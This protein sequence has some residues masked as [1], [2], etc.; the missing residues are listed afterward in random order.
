M[1][2]MSRMWMAVTRATGGGPGVSDYAFD[3]TIDHSKVDEDLFDF[4]LLVNLGA[5][6][7]IDDF[8]AT[9]IFD[10]DTY[11]LNN[12]SVM[13]NKG[14]GKTVV[15]YEGVL[16]SLSP[17]NYWDFNDTIASGTA[18]DQISGENGV[19]YGNPTFESESLLSDKSLSSVDFDG[20]D[21]IESSVNPTLGDNFSFSLIFKADTIPNE[22]G[23][24]CIRQPGG[25]G[26]VLVSLH[27]EA[28]YRMY[29]GM[30]I[31]STW[32]KTNWIGVSVGA[33]YHIAC[34]KDGTTL[35]LYIDGAYVRGIT[36]PEFTGTVAQNPFCIGQKYG[37]EGFSGF[38]GLIDQVATWKTIALSQEQVEELY[39]AF[40]YVEEN[41]IYYN[42]VL[43]LSPK[44]Y[45]TLGD[46]TGETIIIDEL[47][48]NNGTTVNSPSLG[49]PS[50]LVDSTYTAIDFDGST[51]GQYVYLGNSVFDNVRT[52]SFIFKPDI[53][54]QA[55]SGNTG[56]I[57]RWDN[58]ATVSNEN[59]FGF[60]IL[61]TTGEMRF[62]RNIGTTQHQIVSG[63]TVWTSGEIYHIIGIIDSA[64]GMSLYINGVKQLSV[65]SSTEVAQPFDS[66]CVIGSWGSF[67]GSM[68]TFNGVIDEVSVFN[69]ALTETEV[70]YLYNAS[71]TGIVDVAVPSQQCKV[72]IDR[73]DQINEQAQLWVKVPYVSKDVDT[74]INL[75]FDPTNKDNSIN[76]G[77]TGEAP[78]QAVW[79]E[80]DAVYHLSKTD[81]DDYTESTV[82]IYLAQI[83]GTSSTTSIAT[84]GLSAINTGADFVDD[85]LTIDYYIEDISTVI[86]SQIE[87]SSAGT[88]DTDDVFWELDSEFSAV[89]GWN[90]LTLYLRNA[91]NTAG[92][93][94]L[95]AINYIR[96]YAAS[97]IN[98]IVSFQNAIMHV[99][100]ITSNN[101][102]YDSTANSLDGTTNNMTSNNIVDF[103]IGKGLSF[104]GDDEYVVLPDLN[105]GSAGMFTLEILVKSNDSVSQAVV[106]NLND[107][108][109]TTD[110]NT[111]FNINQAGVSNDI[112][113]TVGHNTTGQTYYENSDVTVIN[114]I[115]M[116]SIENGDMIPFLNGLPV[117]SAIT[118]A[119]D[120]VYSNTVL[121]NRI[122]RH[123]TD[124]YP[125]DGNVKEIRFSKSVK[126]PSYMAT[127][128]E[129][130]KDDLVRFSYAKSYIDP[131]APKLYRDSIMEFLPIAY[132]RLGDTAPLSID[133]DFTGDNGDAPNPEL[134]RNGDTDTSPHT[135]QN[136]ALEFSETSGS[137]E[138]LYSSNVSI[139]QVAGDFDIQVDYDLSSFTQPSS[140]SSAHG[141][142]FYFANGVYI[143]VLRNY[144]ASN[145]DGYSI[146]STNTTFA[147][148]TPGVNYANGKF[149]IERIGAVTKAYYWNSSAGQ[150]QWNGS[151]NGFT[152][153]E[154]NTDS[155]NIDLTSS[156][157]N[158]STTIGSFD[159]F[160]V[161]S[162]DLVQTTA[163]DEVG[164]FSGNYINNPTLDSTSLLSN[165][166]NTSVLLNGTDQYIDIDND[167]LDGPVIISV[168][169][170]VKTDLSDN[171]G[172]IR[173]ILDRGESNDGYN[174]YIS[175]TNTI[176]VS[177][178]G[179]LAFAEAVYP[180][181]DSIHHVAFSY[182]KVNVILYLDGA[183]VDRTAYTANISYSPS[184]R[185]NIG[186]LNSSNFFSGNID[187]VSIFDHALSRADINSLYLS[188]KAVYENASYST[189]IEGLSPIAYYKL[190]D[191]TGTILTDQTTLFNG[192]YANSPSLDENGLVVESPN[193]SVFFQGT[194]Q[195]GNLDS[196]LSELKNHSL[197][198]ISFLCNFESG[199]RGYIG[200]GGTI[201]SGTYIQY[202]IDE[203]RVGMYYKHNNATTGAN[204][205]SV[206]TTT[207]FSTSS[208]YHVVFVQDD[209]EGCLIY[210]NGVLQITVETGDSSG[211]RWW[212][213]ST[214]SSTVSINSLRRDTNAYYPGTMDE[215]CFHSIRLNPQNITDLYQASIGNF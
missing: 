133:D 146:N 106:V 188:S 159:N 95:N 72:E 140:S 39:D 26:D 116:T 65:D 42:T 114:M 66:E 153:S 135:I 2:G 144:G 204:N 160:T 23:L 29:L 27:F 25:S 141:F 197:G 173:G 206:V 69:D 59:N 31:S 50:L 117:S 210:I 129:S 4:P 78:A 138:T 169:C 203:T 199:G 134:W 208:T 28:D 193:G 176:K 101:T 189:L 102:V 122:G 211:A 170:L 73:W 171:S 85:Y 194:D 100:S 128:Y 88:P 17:D 30:Y 205:F 87:L 83:S 137:S 24:F 147:H 174:L 19:S 177:I 108:V 86:N 178:N 63:N 93:L 99:R 148:I 61:D 181:D 1:L 49:V 180:D 40:A 112:L 107:S 32:Y 97:S 111:H 9:K 166:G 163:I 143:S 55:G 44:A 105:H 126:T 45:W 70:Q 152:F 13:Y 190:D 198:S 82:D 121:E 145:G 48:N 125:F 115:S 195:Y 202:V 167:L 175:S 80:Y 58:N 20:N 118:G 71:I 162:G 158:G 179:G 127:N 57:Y 54:Y 35:K 16:L 14:A 76:I 47:G 184:P 164:S 192:A 131:H 213:D 150:W 74:V 46:N 132:W 77:N 21:N 33:T 119:G 60:I 53:T 161:V 41:S 151:T 79:D 34:V 214:V 67:T 98:N 89:N 90:S 165:D 8:N 38:K 183:E 191:V 52:I 6:S 123:R 200:F 182:D 103:G 68:R 92:E 154:S 56:L 62:D 185:G 15:D 215:L 196:V 149:R 172:S 109:E 7:G 75:S 81:V 155:I 12:L 96:C 84:V 142:V 120:Y 156:C 10:D 209:A 104:N 43:S 157:K 51:T 113:Y 187:E 124:I 207:A 37:S 36:V 3:I 201:D 212:D 5:D 136:N 18:I 11:P 94:N 130:T 139:F 186:Q 91:Q 22:T 110:P 168:V 64:D